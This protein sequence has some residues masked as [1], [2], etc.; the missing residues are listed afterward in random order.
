MFLSE[1]YM[2]TPTC[3]N[4]RSVGGTCSNPHRQR[5]GDR[6]AEVEPRTLLVHFLREHL[7]LTGTHVGCDTS[8]CG[9][10]TVWLQRRC[11]EV[12]HRPGGPGRGGEVTTIE[13]IAAERRDASHAAGLPRAARAAVRLLHAGHG[14]VGDQAAGGQPQP[15]RRRDPGGAR[16]QPVP[17]HRL[18]EHRRRRYA[19]RPR[20]C[21]H[22]RDR[23][24]GRRRVGAAQGGRSSSSPDEG[25][26]V[27][28]IKLPGM[29]HIAIVRSPYAHAKIVSI[30]GSRALA[31]EGVTAVH[32]PPPT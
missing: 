28:D 12:V 2:T 5:R 11:R 7:S 8:N 17:L 13:G 14:D 4:E 30:D 21:R 1:R 6:T 9:A 20:G 23:I 32:R 18:P 16:R 19:P 29:L 3:P 15:D 31:I 25:R 27:D 24:Q 26:Y 22:E 10:C